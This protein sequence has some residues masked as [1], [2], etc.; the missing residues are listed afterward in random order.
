MCQL[1]FSTQLTY[2]EICLS[3]SQVSGPQQRQKESIFS[4]SQTN[5]SLLCEALMSVQVGQDPVAVDTI[6]SHSAAYVVA[7]YPAPAQ[8]PV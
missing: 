8:E 7:A 1:S 3:K 5:K 6:T 2:E 4:I